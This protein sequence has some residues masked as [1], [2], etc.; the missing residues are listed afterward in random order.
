MGRTLIFLSD[1]AWWVSAFVF[2]IAI[3]ILSS[4]VKEFLDRRRHRLIAKWKEQAEA[5]DRRL[6]EDVRAIAESFEVRHDFMMHLAFHEI[7][8]FKFLLISILG[9]LM[10]VVLEI[11]ISSLPSDPSQ[12]EWAIALRCFYL[13]S[14]LMLV[15]AFTY[16]R[17]IASSRAIL[18]RLRSTL[19]K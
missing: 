15:L 2:G 8:F 16:N 12:S 5:R 4:Y 14:I 13:A 7:M 19:R 17:Y 11:R 3:N 18:S 10:A 1:P 6:Q 9:L